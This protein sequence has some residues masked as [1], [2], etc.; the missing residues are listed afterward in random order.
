MGTLNFRAGKVLLKAATILGR[1]L[2]KNICK[3][4][5]RFKGATSKNWPPGK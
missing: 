3:Y 4:D 5:L 1:T 2:V